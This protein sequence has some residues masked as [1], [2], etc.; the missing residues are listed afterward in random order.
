M[1]RELTWGAAHRDVLVTLLTTAPVRREGEG[2]YLGVAYW[3]FVLRINNAKLGY[4][5]NN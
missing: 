3:P 4:F 2:S 1:G 5:L